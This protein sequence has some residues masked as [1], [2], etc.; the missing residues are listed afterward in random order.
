[1]GKLIIINQEGTELED[2]IFHLQDENQLWI[3]AKGSEKF[4]SNLIIHENNVVQAD[5]L[6]SPLISF[7]NFKALE[8]HQYSANDGITITFDMKAGTLSSF[9]DF[10]IE[11]EPTDPEVDDAQQESSD[12]DESSD[13]NLLNKWLVNPARSWFSSFTTQEIIE[14]PKIELG[15]KIDESKISEWNEISEQQINL[16]KGINELPEND[17]NEKFLKNSLLTMYH[18]LYQGHISLADE[19]TDHNLIKLTDTITQINLSHVDGYSRFQKL[20]SQKSTINEEE[21]TVVDT[22]LVQ[23]G[24]FTELKNSLNELKHTA[25]QLKKFSKVYQDLIGISDD[26]N[27]S[28]YKDFLNIAQANDLKEKVE[29]LL[30]MIQ[31]MTPKQFPY[32]TVK[33]HI[34]SS[35]NSAESHAGIIQKLIKNTFLSEGEENSI[36]NRKLRK[37]DENKKSIASQYRITSWVNPMTIFSSKQSNFVKLNSTTTEDQKDF[38]SKLIDAL[39]SNCPEPESQKKRPSF[40]ASAP[41]FEQSKERVAYNATVG[42]LLSGLEAIKGKLPND[43]SILQHDFMGSVHAL[44]LKHLKNNSFSSVFSD[45]K[46]SINVKNIAD[47]VVNCIRETRIYQ[48]YDAET[49]E[50]TFGRL[51]PS[52]E[53]S[54][55]SDPSSVHTA[56]LKFSANNALDPKTNKT[57]SEFLN[58]VAQLYSEFAEQALLAKQ[59]EDLLDVRE[60]FAVSSLNSI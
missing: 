19:L 47:T 3:S 20:L 51:T 29:K 16:L 7:E 42:A 31:Q 32:T 40:I 26:A 59:H 34:E 18:M 50:N 53:S 6:D 17:N 36:N 55:S 2:A 13:E 28:D 58:R 38:L 45:E 9:T 57:S 15:L 56:E 10:L 39:K 44:I 30:S 35:L 46:M 41:E 4:N 54:S 43:E 21:K 23:A 5:K 48:L 22:Y 49:Q 14:T 37:E 24:I 12:S 33:N 27:H 1:M 60:A 25:H 11:E 8:D 52:T